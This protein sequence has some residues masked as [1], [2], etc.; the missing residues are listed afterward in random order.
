M[1]PGRQIGSS[2]GRSNRIF[3]GRPGDAREGRPR[4][5]LETNI[6]RLGAARGKSKTY[7]EL[8]GVANNKILLKDFKHFS[9]SSTKGS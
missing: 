2:L 6:C 4:D 9:D 8:E 1:S 3:K 7:T 5:I